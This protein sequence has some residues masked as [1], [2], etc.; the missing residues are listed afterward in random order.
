MLV[1]VLAC[2]ELFETGQSVEALQ[3][4]VLAD[5]Y[6]VGETGIGGFLQ[7]VHRVIG[8]V[9]QGADAG[10]VI[11]VCRILRVQ[12]EGLPKHLFRRAQLSLFQ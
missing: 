5:M 8:T 4:G 7:V 3:V 9:L 10:E 2:H 12:V 11:E 6:E 1:S